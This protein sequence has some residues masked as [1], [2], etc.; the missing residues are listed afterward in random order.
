MGAPEAAPETAPNH[1]AIG[2]LCRVHPQTRNHHHVIFPSG[3]ATA[4]N[5][6]QVFLK[7]SKRSSQTLY[8]PAQS[9]PDYFS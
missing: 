1:I 8:L 6:I 7:L 4:K 9:T 2:I 3:P 5:F